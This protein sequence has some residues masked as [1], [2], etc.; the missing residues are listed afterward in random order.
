MKKTGI[1]ISFFT[2]LLFVA[3]LQ[4][5]K[6]LQDAFY[7]S[8]Y[9]VELKLLDFINKDTGLPIIVTRIFHNKVVVSIIELYRH[10][11]SYWDI[12]FLNISLGLIGVFGLSAGIYY[13]FSRRSKLSISVFG[14]AVLIPFLFEVLNPN[15][16][17]I[18]KIIFLILPL[19][20]LSVYGISTFLSTNSRWRFLTVFIL[21]LISLWWFF[22]FQDL[23]LY[24][25]CVKM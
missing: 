11:I 19:L 7:F 12:G 8:S 5:C 1:I 9:D 18:L 13:A 21:C 10:Y 17:F 22:V 2:S 25:F 24:D 15:L 3:S 23:E 20:T 14:L 16:P 6:A 4:K